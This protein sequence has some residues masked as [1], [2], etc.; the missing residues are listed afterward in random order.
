M[1]MVKDVNDHKNLA[2]KFI[3][4][5]VLGQIVLETDLGSILGGGRGEDA[6]NVEQ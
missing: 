6:I 2:R 1:T 5:R 3:R 4:N